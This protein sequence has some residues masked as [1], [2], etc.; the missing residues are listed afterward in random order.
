MHV[1]VVAVTIE[2]FG[3]ATNVE[4]FFVYHVHIEQES[5]IVVSKWMRVINQN[6]SLEMFY[7]LRVVSDLEVGKTEVVV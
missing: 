4:C 3:L 7:S 1:R 2:F 6:A 5:Q